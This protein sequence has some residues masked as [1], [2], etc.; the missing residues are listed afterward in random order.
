MERGGADEYDLAVIDAIRHAHHS[1]TTRQSITIVTTNEDCENRLM[2]EYEQRSSDIWTVAGVCD[3]CLLGHLMDSRTP[4]V[5]WIRNTKVGYRLARSHHNNNH[6]VRFIDVQHMDTTTDKLG[7]EH[8]SH[9][10][11]PFLAHR[12]VVSQ[13]LQRVLVDK[14]GESASRVTV[15]P[16]PVD[17]TFWA[18]LG[19]GR[20]A[21][22]LLFVGRFVEQKR[23]DLFV[24]VCQ[25]LPDH[26][27]VMIGADHHVLQ[28]NVSV[29]PWT[30]D[31]RLLREYF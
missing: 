4:S 13:R 1:A 16:P 30:S 6:I 29:L 8:Y 28:D 2:S 10:F 15:I 26:Q 12:V 31:K 27:C 3:D 22:L 24:R 17:T 14:F 23:P 11:S 21:K 5:V 19:S 18:C 25:S 9:R 20:E 7:F